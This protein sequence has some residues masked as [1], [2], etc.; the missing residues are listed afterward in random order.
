MRT[1]SIKGGAALTGLAAL[2]TAGTALAVGASSADS[3]STDQTLPVSTVAPG[4]GLEIEMPPTLS[5]VMGEDG[6]IAIS[7]PDL[8][9]V[10]GENSDGSGQA[11]PLE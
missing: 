8:E 10:G 3:G 7:I 4:H 1:R 11:A 2:A 9:A 5:V 6:N